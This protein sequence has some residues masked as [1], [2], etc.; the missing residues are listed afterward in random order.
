MDGQRERL[1]VA[2]PAEVGRL[3]RRGQAAVQAGDEAVPIPA[4]EGVLRSARDTG[5]G[6]GTGQSRRVDVPG[7]GMNLEVVDL[8]DAAASEEGRLRQRGE[9]TVQAGDERV[10]ETSAESRLRSPGRSREWIGS[11]LAPHVD[12]SARG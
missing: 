2:A 12:V 11:G 3:G 7:R 4:T 1:V 8:V 5:E 6:I 10:V 9:G